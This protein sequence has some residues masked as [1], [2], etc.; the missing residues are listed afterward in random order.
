MYHYLL[1][2]DSFQLR[3]IF[4]PG[5]SGNYY[6]PLL[7]VSYMM[8]KYIWGLEE[9]FMHLENIVFHLINTLLVFLIAR[10]ASKVFCLR[11]LTVPFVSALLFA[12]HPINTEAVN[13]ISGRT[14]LLAGIFI[15]SA[16]FLLV[17][18]TAN[19]LASLCAAVCLF[20]ACLAKETAVFFLPA[21]ILL[22]FY[23]YSGRDSDLKFSQVILKHIQHFIYFISSGVGYFALRNLAYNQ[24][25]QGV[26]RVFSH[27][28][29]EAS[30]GSLTSLW[31]VL[32]ASGFYLK[33]L[34]IPF[35]LNFGI[36]HVSDLY[37]VVGVMTWFLF[38]WILFKRTVPGYFFL[39]SASIGGSAFLI[40]LLKLAWTPLAERYMYMPSAFF[41]IGVTLAVSDMKNRERFQP[42]LVGLTGIVLITAT[43]GTAS[44]NLLWQNNLALFQDTLNKSPEFLP[45]RNEIANALNAQGRNQEAIN[46]LK[47]IEIPQNI[48][49]SQIGLISK[50]GALA[51][52]GNI[53]G[54]RSLLYKALESPGKYEKQ[55]VERLLALYDYEVMNHK[56]EVN[57]TFAERERLLIRLFKITGDFFYQYRLGQLYLQVGD[58]VKARNSFQQVVACTSEKVYFY[59]PSEKL[60]KKLIMQ[61]N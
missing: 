58:R 51:Q 26:Q 22:P 4:L 19:S 1:N 53:G 2:N 8:D 24:G 59:Q 52:E 56:V 29:G 37:I 61:G 60:V 55:I 42:V 39:C 46:V 13:W 5:G 30:A 14:D 7:I 3:S 54:A 44:R 48:S 15:F 18:K 16:V 49:N 12:L 11:S 33:K 10:S 57:H 40:P 21:A 28:A 6:R 27:V 38:V 23:L 25:D 32:K 34:L 35:P 20:L 43:F 47:S 36:I 45:A 17:R 9:S 50:S 41:L 31:M